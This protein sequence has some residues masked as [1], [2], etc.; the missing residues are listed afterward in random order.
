MFS[1]VVV[2]VISVKH[3][4]A[5]DASEDVCNKH[6]SAE[7]KVGWRGLAALASGLVYILALKPRLCITS[8]STELQPLE[9]I[10]LVGVRTA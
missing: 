5:S 1:V 8:V 4:I 9:M 6:L 7:I 2:F 3:Y 10:I